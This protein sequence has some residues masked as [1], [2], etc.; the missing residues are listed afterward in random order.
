MVAVLHGCARSAREGCERVCK[1]ALLS[2]G[3]CASECGLQKVV[4]RVGEWP[5][6]ARRG[7]IHGGVRGRARANGRSALIGRTH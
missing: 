2:E 7:D 1:G 3:E 4:G 6:N 5:G